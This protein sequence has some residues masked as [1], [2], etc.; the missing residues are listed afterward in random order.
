MSKNYKILEKDINYTFKNKELIK[1]ALTHSSVSKTFNYERMEFLGDSLLSVIVADY[2]YK[3]SNKKVGD[4]SILRSNLV[5]TDALSKIVLKNNWKDLIVVGPSV[6]STKNVVKNVLADIFESITA[7][8]FLDSGI[9]E[10]VAFVN[11]YI[12]N[13]VENVVNN[14]Y[15]TMLQE[16]VAGLNHNAK[17]EYKLIESFGPSHELNFVMGLYYNDNLV[18]KAE[19]KNKKEAEQMCAKQFLEEVENNGLTS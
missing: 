12:L 14:D 16:K 2:L 15:K 5:S 11:K 10:T 3:N 17:L 7:A 4:M 6:I 1:K 8:I 19:G 18:S 9:N 13:D